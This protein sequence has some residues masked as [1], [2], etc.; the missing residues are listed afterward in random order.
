MALTQGPPG[1][2]GWIRSLFL[3]LAKFP[4]AQGVLAYLVDPPTRAAVLG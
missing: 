1:R 3:M 4:Q 2:P